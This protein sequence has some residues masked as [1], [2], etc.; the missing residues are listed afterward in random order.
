MITYEGF[1]A[2]LPSEVIDGTAPSPSSPLFAYVESLLSIL[3]EHS[4]GIEESL[5]QH[6]TTSSTTDNTTRRIFEPELSNLYE[7]SVVL[8]SSVVYYL[9]QGRKTW[10]DGVVAQ[11]YETTAVGKRLLER[12]QT[13]VELSVRACQES[14]WLGGW[15]YNPEG[16]VPILAVVFSAGTYYGNSREG[17]GLVVAEF[18]SYM[19]DTFE[20]LRLAFERLKRRVEGSS[21]NGSS[22]G[23]SSNRIEHD[24]EWFLEPFSPVRRLPVSR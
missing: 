22:V 4:E 19:G 3:A 20:L 17:L 7:D 6:H 10:G 8:L 11:V 12:T 9:E 5:L 1:L 2:L 23:L 14:T 18:Q 24:S 15:S 21:N 16:F 13:F